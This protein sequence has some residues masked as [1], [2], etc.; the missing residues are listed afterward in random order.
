MLPANAAWPQPA[1]DTSYQVSITG[2]LIKDL[3]D[4][5]D[6]IW[7]IAL[8]LIVFGLIDAAA[9]GWT[10]AALRATTQ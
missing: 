10:A 7:L 6:Q 4:S 3:L 2:V 1:S 5:A 9:A 8:M